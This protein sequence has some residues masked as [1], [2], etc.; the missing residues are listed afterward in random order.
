MAG[1]QY[2]SYDQQGQGMQGDSILEA[3]NDLKTD[4]LKGKIS[5]LRTVSV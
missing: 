1:Y 4:E 5:A 3:D 2:P